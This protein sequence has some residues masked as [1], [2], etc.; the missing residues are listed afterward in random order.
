LLEV[1]NKFLSKEGFF[2]LKDLVVGEGILE[3]E[4]R[5]FEYFSKYGLNFGKLY[6]LNIVSRTKYSI[7][8]NFF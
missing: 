1:T 4:K 7:I 2:D 3:I 8:S 5:G 6:I